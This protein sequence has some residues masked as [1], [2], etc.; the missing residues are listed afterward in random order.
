MPS[1]KLTY[2]PVKALG[3]PIRFLF[4]Y[5][6]IPFE[7]VRFDREDWPKIKPTTPYGQVPMLEVDGKKVAQSTA[8]CRYLAKKAGLV[9]KDDWE[10][11]E[12]DATVDTIHDLRARL[13]AFHYEEDP[14]TKAAKEKVVEEQVPPYLERLDA[15][16]AKN[17]GYFV[18]GA[19][20]WADLLF[21]SLLDYLNF[22]N[23]KTDLIEK[24]ENLKQLRD[25]V[26]ALPAIKTWV[27]SRP[28]SEC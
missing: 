28:E 5:A 6:G 24:Y 3:E 27:E 19:L 2:F 12:I 15:Q 20:S 22:M 16:V 13:A 4:S 21:V 17:G 23:K 7:D 18:G 9:G 10:A 11:L 1:Y 26:L 8:I 14:N 25:K